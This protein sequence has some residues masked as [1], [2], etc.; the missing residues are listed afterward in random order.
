MEF[1]YK[2]NAQRVLKRVAKREIAG[3]NLDLFKFEQR[4]STT[5]SKM[6]SSYEASS[7]DLSYS[8]QSTVAARSPLPRGNTS[9]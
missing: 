9:S 5:R 4:V 2:Q 3:L 6:C 1:E 7:K 8:V